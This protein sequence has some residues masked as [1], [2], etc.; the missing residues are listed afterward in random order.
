M[1][2]NGYSFFEQIKAIAEEDV[3]FH[4]GENSRC[5]VQI[6]V[7]AVK[8][9]TGTNIHALRMKL[10]LSQYGLAMAL[11]VSKRT[12]EAWEAQKNTPSGAASHLLYL[13]EQEPELLKKLIEET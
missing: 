12:V 4:K 8:A 11:G 6:R 1:E 3:Q 13:I 10:H 7:I 2:N 9:Y 5:G